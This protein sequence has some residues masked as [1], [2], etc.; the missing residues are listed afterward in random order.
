MIDWS[1]IAELR[2]EIGPEDFDE[3][4]DLFLTEVLG[5]IET[6]DEAVGKPA[7]MEEQMHFLKGAALNLGFS[8]L[9][10]ICEK[11]EHAA[12]NGDAH[13]VSPA[14]IRACF[15]ESS[16]QYEEQYPERFAA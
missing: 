2:D 1:R 4:S 6:I 3:V 10:T 12:A 8:A 15:A 13:A 9:S 11:G 7:L 14:E 5:I 16:A